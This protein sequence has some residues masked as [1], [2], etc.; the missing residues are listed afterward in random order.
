MPTFINTRPQQRALPLSDALTNAGL[1]VVD[2]PLLEM[3]A[4]EPNKDDKQKL[5]AIAQSTYDVLV[6]V[7][8]TAA[9]LGMRSIKSNQVLSSQTVVAVGDATAQALAAN[10][11]EAITPQSLSSTHH[12]VTGLNN[13]NNNEGMLKLPCIQQLS[14]G[15]RVM[16]WRGQGGRRLL[17][18]SLQ[19]RG[20]LVDVIELYKRQL[21]EQTF[22]AYKNWAAK[23]RAVED[24]PIVLIS[25]NE[26]FNNWHLV[27]AC[28][29][30]YQLN[31]FIY[32]VLGSRL[33][34]IVQQKKLLFK[35]IESL[36]PAHIINQLA[37]NKF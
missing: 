26:A 9:N 6:V 5:Q 19:E 13:L 15:S 12:P 8:P 18:D 22:L 23:K 34:N 10:G 1:T 29:R 20:V 30:H 37:G 32:L 35:Q 25:S 7:S 28:N 17:I 21:P 2:L 33:A 31:D 36:N 11:V 14:S 4:I 27:V 3:I 16:V 24:S